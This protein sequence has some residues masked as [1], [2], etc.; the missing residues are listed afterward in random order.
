MKDRARAA[1]AR[2]LVFA[3]AG[4]WPLGSACRR[5]DPLP[6]FPEAPVLLISI[7]TLRADRLPAYGYRGVATPHLDRFRQDAILYRNAYSPCP[8]TLPSHVSMLT[9]LLPPEHGVRNNVGFTFDGEAHPSLP[10]LLKAKGYATG[11]AVSSY[12]L[13]GETGLGALFDDYE[14]SLDPRHGTAFADQQRPGGVTTAFA[15]K[16]IEARGASRFFYFLHLYEPHVPYDP[17]EP[18]RSRYPDRYDGE[19]AAADDIVGELLEPLRRL[20]V[21]DRALI[22]VTSDHGEGLGDHGED[23]HSILLY[24]EV[25]RVPLLL[26]LPGARLAGT[27]VEAPGQ[28]IDLVPT[29]AGLVGFETPAGLRGR[30]LLH[31]EEASPRAAYAETLY[32]RLQLG[33]SDLKSLVD[34]RWHYIHGPRPELYDQGTDPGEKQDLIAREGERAERMRAELERYPTGPQ[35]PRPVDPATAERLAALG[36]VGAARHRTGAPLPNPREQLPS[37]ERLRQGFRLSGERRFEEAAGELARLVKDQPGMVEGWTKLG[38]VLQEAGQPA[39]AAAAFA[40]ALERSPVP[41]PDIALAK[42]YAHLRAGG[43]FE[44]TEAAHRAQPALPF[45]AHE[46]LARVALARNRL[47]D[48]EQEAAAAADPRGPQPSAML[49]RAEV[50]TRQGDYPG[51]LAALGQARA[52]ADALSLGA[53]F[54]LEALRGDALA[55]LGRAGEADAAYRQEVGAFPGNLVAWANRAALL[56]AA[57]RRAEVEPLFQTMAAANPGAR[58]CRVAAAAW[59]AFGDHER[60]KGWRVREAEARSQRR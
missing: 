38:E 17:P 6:T 59:E 16:W 2:L 10:R 9:G 19:I 60:A 24:R 15:R 1:A 30:S 58:A 23:Q 31:L 54:N 22:V 20:G 46:L 25:L 51:A 18:F 34:G 41:L 32:P 53:V 48:A 45:G 28:L 12:V 21:Y 50:K 42:G 5:A 27:T 26:K 37:L 47:T 40:A 56:F 39:E 4:A 55:R 52:R 8:M 36:Y 11:A 35:A 44:A 49:L 13:R 43:L 14:D 3:F 57:G 29:V 7:D 33:W